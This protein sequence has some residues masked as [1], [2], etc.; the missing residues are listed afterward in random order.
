MN[1]RHFGTVL[2]QTPLVTI[3]R[4]VH[5]VRLYCILMYMCAYISDR[6]ID[7]EFKPLHSTN[8]HYTHLYKK[9]KE[10]SP[11]KYFCYKSTLLSMIK[12]KLR[13]GMTNFQR[14]NH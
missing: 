13:N 3:T 12:K 1:C 11:T 9:Y 2:F 4:A 8:T 14:L 7:A 5:H 6:E 10:G